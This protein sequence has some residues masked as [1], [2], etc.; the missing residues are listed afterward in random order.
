M[1]RALAK[2]LDKLEA[3]ERPIT[4]APNVLQ[5]HRE[6]TIAD[7]LARFAATHPDTPRGHRL[8]IVPCRDRTAEEDAD[9]AVRFKV[10]QRQLIADAQSRR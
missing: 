9:F 2:R 10:Q 4:R 5:V 1:I 8:L 3:I 7:A 6:E